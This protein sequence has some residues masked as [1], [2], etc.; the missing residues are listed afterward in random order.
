[1]E[2]AKTHECPRKHH[3]TRTKLHRTNDESTAH[4]HTRRG[5]FPENSGCDRD[6]RKP[7]QN[8]KILRYEKDKTVINTELHVSLRSGIYVNQKC[9][10]DV[11]YR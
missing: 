6:K 2:A 4:L 7:T 5:T 10:T 8:S 1:M 11:Q 9:R 3:V